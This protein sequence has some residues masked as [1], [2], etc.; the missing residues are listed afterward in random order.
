MSAKK[1]NNIL[2][3]S[4]AVG[5]TG[6]GPL[7]GWMGYPWQ[8]EPFRLWSLLDIMMRFSSG[9]LLQ[10]L[11]LLD[12]AKDAL[13]AAESTPVQP[14]GSTMVEYAGRIFDTFIQ[15][16]DD[17]G[18]LPMTLRSQAAGVRY[19]FRNRPAVALVATVEDLR[20]CIV[21]ELQSQMFFSIPAHRQPAYLDHRAW[22]GETTIDRFPRIDGDVRDACQCYAFGQWTAT[23]FHSMRILER[24]LHVLG[25]RYGVKWPEE[26]D[27]GAII[28]LITKAIKSAGG[29]G[30]DPKKARIL[31]ADSEAAAQFH[32]IKNAWRNHVAHSKKDY[33]EQ[34]AEQVLVHVR[35]FMRALA[36]PRR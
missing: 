18:P 9:D 30:G 36:K 19:G 25:N 17:L 16:W 15:K 28:D 29:S 23:V 35:D 5:H 24:G 22:F 4:D 11:A 12:A 33:D 20:D 6:D 2:D 32:F 21:F 14:D 7:R 13:K 34:A 27:W 8:S 3:S 31:Q 1:G 10:A 26:K